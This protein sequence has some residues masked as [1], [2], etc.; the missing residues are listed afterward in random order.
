[1]FIPRTRISELVLITLTKVIRSDYLDLEQGA[2]LS[3][4]N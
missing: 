4:I 3:D 1:M 2:D